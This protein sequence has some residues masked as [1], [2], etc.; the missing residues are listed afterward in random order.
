LKP[1][2]C[3]PFAFSSDGQYNDLNRGTDVNRLCIADQIG[4]KV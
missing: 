3:V 2:D 1:T 4:D